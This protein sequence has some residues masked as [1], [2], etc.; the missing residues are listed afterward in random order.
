V[1]VSASY[2]SRRARYRDAPLFLTPRCVLLAGVG[3]G[4]FTGADDFV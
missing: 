2:L 4:V 1:P 3:L